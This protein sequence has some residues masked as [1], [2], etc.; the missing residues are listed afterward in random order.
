M[1]AAQ[2]Y[3]WTPRSDAR[4]VT[5]HDGHVTLDLVL[6][7]YGPGADSWDV[8]CFNSSVRWRTGASADGG[9]P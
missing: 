7:N 6:A 8:D 4:V 9:A 3:F 5:N 2:D 1:S